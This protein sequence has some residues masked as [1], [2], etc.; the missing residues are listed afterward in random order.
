MEMETKDRG[1]TEY[2]FLVY[3]HYVLTY[4][5]ETGEELIAYFEE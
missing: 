5:D 3:Q 1:E 4:F 2:S